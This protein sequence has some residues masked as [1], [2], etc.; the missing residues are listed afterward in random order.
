MLAWRIWPISARLRKPCYRQPGGGAGLPSVPCAIP[1]AASCW[2]IG[3]P[4][5]YGVTARVL[6]RIGSVARRTGRWQFAI[7]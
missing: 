2:W 4:L 1:H 5:G 6:W 7:A 3:M